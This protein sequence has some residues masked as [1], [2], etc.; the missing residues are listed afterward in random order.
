KRII[1][2][3]CYPGVYEGE[4]RNALSRVFSATEIFSVSDALKSAVDI[5]RMLAT[6]L[7]DDPVFG[8][9]S[10]LELIEF[11]DRRAL[12][13]LTETVRAKGSGVVVGTG[14]S[15]VIENPDFLIYANLAR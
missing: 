10:R 3:E 1:C 5:D 11:F 4:I 7:S 8:H 12:M 14:A 13:Q 2:I 9:L 6:D 15:L